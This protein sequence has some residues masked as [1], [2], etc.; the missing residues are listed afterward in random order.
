MRKYEMNVMFWLEKLT[1][2]GR[3][4]KSHW[5]PCSEMKMKY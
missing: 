3:E 4:G 1:G 2:R 5:D